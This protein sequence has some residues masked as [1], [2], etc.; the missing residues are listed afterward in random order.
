MGSDCK[1]PQLH[2][3][4]LRRG[5]L[6]VGRK[7]DDAI[8]ASECEA[9]PVPR[10]ST[11][12]EAY[13]HESLLRRPVMESPFLMQESG[14][15]VLRTKQQAAVRPGNDDINV[16]GDKSTVVRMVLLD[17]P[18]VCNIIYKQSRP[19]RT[20]IQS[21]IRRLVQGADMDRLDRKVYTTVIPPVACQ[22]DIG[23][24]WYRSTSDPY[25]SP[26]WW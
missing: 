23:P 8:I 17:E 18:F 13:A 19:S 24:W 4:E 16:V 1:V 9:V 25:P 14:N 21:A 5:N 20:H 12:I 3:R 11:G 26:V 7:H 10:R 15:T 6:Q 22:A 2:P